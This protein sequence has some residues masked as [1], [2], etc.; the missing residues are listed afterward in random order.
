M[1]MLMKSSKA[2][3]SQ[4]RKKRALGNPCFLQA[5]TQVIAK[6]GDRTHRGCGKGRCI[7]RAR[8]FSRKAALVQE[9]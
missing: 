4:T 8:P 1:M 9:V 2:S 6:V 5:Q 3:Q 7:L